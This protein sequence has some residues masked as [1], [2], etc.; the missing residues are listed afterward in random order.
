MIQSYFSK[1]NFNRKGSG[2]IISSFSL[3]GTIIFL[4]QSLSDGITHG[5]KVAMV[6]R[7]LSALQ[8]LGRAEK[9]TVPQASS[10]QPPHRAGPGNSLHWD[11][12]THC[13][14]TSQANQTAHSSSSP[15]QKDPQAQAE[16]AHDM[17]FC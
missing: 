16:S 3:G 17:C 8:L 9:D 10:Q 15:Q 14:G 1:A 12:V 2:L 7:V 5:G 4:T 11:L 6:F 13:T